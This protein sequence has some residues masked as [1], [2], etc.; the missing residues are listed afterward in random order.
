M[1]HAPAFI[2]LL[3]GVRRRCSTQR[4]MKAN[5][6]QQSSG[7]QVDPVSEMSQQVTAHAVP[8]MTNDT[9]RSTCWSPREYL[10]ERVA[11]QI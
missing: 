11:N 6:L 2:S 8:D 4:C 3:S 7:Q 5:S 9:C 1:G 10:Y